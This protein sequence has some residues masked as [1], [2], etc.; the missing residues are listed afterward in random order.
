MQA[1]GQPRQYLLYAALFLSFIGGTVTCLSAV[2]AHQ[3]EQLIQDGVV[4]SAVIEDKRRSRTYASHVYQDTYWMTLAL[5]GDAARTFRWDVTDS[6]YN[7]HQKG[8]V[9]NIV[10]SRSDPTLFF[11]GE[12]SRPVA[13]KL[14]AEQLIR[15]GAITFLIG[16]GL[17]GY[18][19]K[20]KGKTA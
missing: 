7:Q 16:S 2:L 5:V 6:T 18:A 19:L 15:L 8:D 12:A 11:A 3:S 20:R 9:V 1:I 4:G 17:T 14:W 10:F 13:M